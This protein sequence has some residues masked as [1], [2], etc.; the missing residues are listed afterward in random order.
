MQVWYLKVE[1]QNKMDELERYSCQLPLRGFGEKGQEKLK[2]AR[3]LIVGAG[4]LGCP[5][6]A[7]LAGVGVG[8][9][10][11]VDFDI[12]S[13]SNLHRQILFTEKDIGKSKAEVA[14]EKLRN[15]NSNIEVQS[16]KVRLDSE[17]VRSIIEP[18]DIVIDCT[19]NF[20]TR[21]SL[22]DACVLS[23]K[24]LIY[25]AILGFE[26]QVATWNVKDED[27]SYSSNYRDIFPDMKDGNVPTCETGGVLPTIAGIV[28]CIQAT[29]AIKFIIG[30]DQMLI[31]KLLI[32]DILNLQS[33]IISLPKS[34]QTK[35]TKVK[36]DQEI[37]IPQITGKELREY[38]K[39]NSCNLID[40][41]TNEEHEL[42]NIGGE[43][44][45]LEEFLSQK[46]KSYKKM[47][48]F[49]CRS[50]MRS[51]AAV[52]FVLENDPKANVFSLSGGISQYNVINHA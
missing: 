41:R 47:T 9:I 10:G 36:S 32:F 45:P 18:F 20:S 52:R 8:K 16:L 35:I 7:Y 5:V 13:I 27:G 46:N 31:N 17:N 11:I 34:T 24:P 38:L 33:K 28:G 44:I 50:G 43:N 21:Y 42:Q 37:K 23:G 19:D 30:N 40:V 12:V 48:V 6:G 51:S 1:R 3:V 2:K 49:Y 15:I 4:G 26:G 39:K 29:E 25:G 14:S 22:N